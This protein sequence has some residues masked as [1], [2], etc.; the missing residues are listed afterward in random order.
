MNK[1]KR[2]SNNKFKLNFLGKYYRYKDRKYRCINATKIK[3]NKQISVFLI[4]KG[5]D[6]E[7]IEVD[8][9]ELKEIK[10]E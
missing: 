7:V 2:R 5:Q 8:L 10:E 9:N 3:T 4:L 1:R 6:Q